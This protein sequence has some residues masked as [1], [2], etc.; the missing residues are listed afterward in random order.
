MAPAIL[1]VAVIAYSIVNYSLDRFTGDRLKRSFIAAGFATIIT[2][3]PLALLLYGLSIF[4]LVDGILEWARRGFWNETRSLPV[5]Y[6]YLLVAGV[7]YGVIFG[8]FLGL[9][10]GITR[11]LTEPWDGLRNWFDRSQEL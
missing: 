3:L 2:A 6:S 9:L 1:S 5:R 8:A 11:A 4:D 10:I 7:P